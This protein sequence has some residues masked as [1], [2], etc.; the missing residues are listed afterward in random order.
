MFI[1]L[2]IPTALCSYSSISPQIYVPTD[3]CSHS[4]MSPQLCSYSS[5][6][7]Q[8]CIPIAPCSRGSMLPQFYVTTVLCSHITALNFQLTLSLVPYF[9]VWEC[10]AHRIVVGMETSRSGDTTA[11][12]S[13]Q[14]P[15]IKPYSPLTLLVV[16]F[17]VLS[18]YHCGQTKQVD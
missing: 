12:R 11:N 6:S 8:L 10:R 4:S 3:L 1:Q 7:P 18:N 9:E 15:D 14:S 17:V 16:G 5:I 13:W 2:Y